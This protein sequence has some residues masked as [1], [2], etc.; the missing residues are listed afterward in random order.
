MIW[1]RPDLTATKK[2][3][4]A[5]DGVSALFAVVLVVL[6]QETAL[7]VG[8]QLPWGEDLHPVLERT[9]EPRRH[10]R[11]SFLER[12]GEVLD[13]NNLPYERRTGIVLTCGEHSGSREGQFASI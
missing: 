5:R 11:M 1:C 4:P 2:E 9:V 6:E 3:D 10:A 7:R 12:P 8:A 13:L